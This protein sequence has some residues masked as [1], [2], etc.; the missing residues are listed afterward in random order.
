MIRTEIEIS[1]PV[2]DAWWH[3]LDAEGWKQWWGG[4]LREVRPG[5]ENG[6]EMVRE[7]FICPSD[8]P[9]FRE[10]PVG[11]DVLH[12]IRDGGIHRQEAGPS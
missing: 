2:E 4:N 5:W 6:A 3:L 10:V 1:R 8:G 9:V 11:L 7:G 12:R